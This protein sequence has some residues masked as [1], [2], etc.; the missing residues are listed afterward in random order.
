MPKLAYADK[1][2]PLEGAEVVF[3]V[4]SF[5]ASTQQWGLASLHTLAHV[6][7]GLGRAALGYRAA[8]ALL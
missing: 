5:G 1:V 4:F 3:I 8:Q 2:L 6:A 7:G